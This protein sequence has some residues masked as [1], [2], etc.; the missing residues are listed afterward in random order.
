MDA[1][2][3][4]GAG[5][6]SKAGVPAAAGSAGSAAQEGPGRGGPVGALQ[7]ALSHLSGAPPM[8]QPTPYLM[9]PHSLCLRG[10]GL[11]GMSCGSGGYL[12]HNNWRK[13][14]ARAVATCT[15]NFV[16]DCAGGRQVCRR[17]ARRC[18]EHA[19]QAVP[20]AAQRL[21]EAERRLCGKAPAGKQ[22]SRPAASAAGFALHTSTS[23]ASHATLQNRGCWHC[24]ELQQ[25]DSAVGLLVH[26]RHVT[27]KVKR[28]YLQKILQNGRS[29]RV[30]G[31][32]GVCVHNRV[33]WAV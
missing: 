13:L 5:G 25:P 14:A 27:C 9:T 29:V 2:V 28:I 4:E 26:A 10:P 24:T 32:D 8:P 1:E 21:P 11:D 22:S 12:R 17:S 31:V 15:L 16:C 19:Q 7:K 30:S 23:S 18:H 6:E 3:S 20:E 33:R